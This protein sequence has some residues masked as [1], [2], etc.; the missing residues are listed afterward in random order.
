MQK[1]KIRRLTTG[2]I[3]KLIF[4]GSWVGSIPVFLVLGAF[5]V[6]GVE[7]LSWN[8]QYITGWSALIGG[9]LLGLFLSSLFGAV[10][11]S[12]T[13]LGHWLLSKLGGL[14]LYCELD[15]DPDEDAA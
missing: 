12:I 5:A 4:F 8:G 1:H 11:A 7:L 2:S 6:T 13:A 3:Y 10:V 9:P 15:E 14:S